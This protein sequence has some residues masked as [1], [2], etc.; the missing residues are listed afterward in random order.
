MA[1]VVVQIHVRALRSPGNGGGNTAAELHLQKSPRG[2]PSPH[3][4]RESPVASFQEQFSP[5]GDV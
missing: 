3:Q 1:T 4:P 2:F 5:P